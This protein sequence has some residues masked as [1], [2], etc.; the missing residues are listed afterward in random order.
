L[1][2]KAVRENK[3]CWFR[4]K[5]EED[6]SKVKLE[7]LHPEEP[8]NP[9]Q[10]V[11]NT[12]VDNIMIKWLTDWKVPAKHWNHWRAAILIK[13]Y[14][15][16]PPDMVKDKTK[17]EPAAIAW[18][19]KGKRHFASLAKWFNPGVIAHEQTHNSYALLS[20]KKKAEFSKVYTPLKTNDPLI[21]YLY[22]INGYGL[23]DDIEGHAE[24]YRYLGE[25]MPA[26]LK[27]YYPKL[28]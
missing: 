4:K 2:N 19:E 24:V 10:K 9:G 25:T 20:E 16:W 11:A 5:P 27:K 28:M 22:S 12:S 6:R 7:I 15:S 23:Q 21:M 14:D 1:E 3:M 17:P 13:I 18:E 26:A 8:P